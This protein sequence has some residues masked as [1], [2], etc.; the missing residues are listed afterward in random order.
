MTISYIGITG[1]MQRAE[2]ET[3]LS[4]L[5]KYGN[6]K[7]M[8]GALASS[9]TLAGEKNRYPNRYP[10]KE[11]IKDIFINHPS[12]LNLIHYSTDNYETLYD[13]LSTLHDYAGPLCHGYQL[14]IPWPDSKIINRFRFLHPNTYIVLQ[15]GARAFSEI[16]HSPPRLALKI[17]QDYCD[18]V[19]AVLLDMSGGKGFSLDIK[20]MR[21]YIQGIALRNPHMGIGIAGGLDEKSV[22]ELKSL[23]MEYLFLN[24]DAEGRLR[25]EEDCLDLIKARRYCANGFKIFM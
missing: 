3:I 21:Q 1:F 15:I 7:V 22:L 10:E 11:A 9:K 14:N 16:G 25:N 17:K 12:A 6:R 5:P 24:I 19:D 8:I 2:T 23:V 18:T 13:Q 20:C 4:C